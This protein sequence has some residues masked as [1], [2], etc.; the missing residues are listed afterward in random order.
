MDDQKDRLVLNQKINAADGAQFN[1]V[2]THDCNMTVKAAYG[3]DGV[4]LLVEINDDNNVA[5]PNNLAGTENEQFYLNF[6][7]VDILVDSRSVSSIGEVNNRDMFLSKSF[8]LTSTTKQYQV[9]CGTEKERPTGFKRSIP[10][11][12]DFYGRYFTFQD[13]KSQLGIEI[14]NINPGYYIKAQ[15]WFIPWS[16]YGGGFEIEPDAGTRLGFTAGFNDRDEGEHFPPGVSSSGGSVKA[17]N[18]LRWIGKTD[19][20]GSNKPPFGWGELELGSALSH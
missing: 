6:D 14:E 7:A 13:A 11:P 1:P 17:S 16:E 10:D 5:W 9:A 20:W 15:E 2:L 4:Y 19:P 8:G 3:G 12:W 18:A